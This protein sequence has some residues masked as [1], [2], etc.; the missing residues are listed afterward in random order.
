[1][2]NAFRYYQIE[3]LFVISPNKPIF[4]VRVSLDT[5]SHI[6]FLITRWW[7]PL[8]GSGM[9]CIQQMPGFKCPSKLWMKSENMAQNTLHFEFDS[10][11]SIIELFEYVH[12]TWNSCMVRPGHAYGKCYV[13]I[14]H[15]FS[16][17]KETWRWHRLARDLQTSLCFPCGIPGRA[18]LEGGPLNLR[19]HL[20]CTNRIDIAT[21]S[22]ASERVMSNMTHLYFDFMQNVSCFCIWHN[23]F[24][25]ECC[26]ETINFCN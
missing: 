16:Y 25:H 18:F 2:C 8:V 14:E 12:S 26:I 19:F 22:E 15:I 23:I 13:Q 3:D 6:L 10:A 1:M 9:G 21:P 4:C 17:T 5:S 11:F 24:E 7:H 20:C